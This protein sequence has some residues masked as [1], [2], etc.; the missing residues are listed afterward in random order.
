MADPQR[1]IH[2]RAVYEMAA[3]DMRAAEL[4]FGSDC[5]GSWPSIRRSLA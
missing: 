5:V 1:L 2:A 4:D 3:I